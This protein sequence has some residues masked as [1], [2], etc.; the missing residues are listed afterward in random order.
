MLRDF[1]ERED[2]P[3]QA[4]KILCGEKVATVDCKAG[5]VKTQSGATYTADLVVGADG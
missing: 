1:V 2:L 5:I 3:G 4:P